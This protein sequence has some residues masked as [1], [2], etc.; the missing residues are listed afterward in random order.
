[1]RNNPLN[2]SDPTGRQGR[3]PDDSWRPGDPRRQEIA[4]QTEAAPVSLTEVAAVAVEVIGVLWDIATLPTGA[5]SGPEGIVA[6][7]AI[8]AGIRE[9]GETAAEGA[10]RA[11]PD[12]ITNS[13]GVTMSTSRDYNLVDTQTPTNRGGD[14][15]QIHNTHEHGGVSPHTH[16]PG[17][18]NTGAGGQSRARETQATT[19][20][21][22]TRAD[23]RLRSGELRE[24]R[25]RRD[26][27]GTP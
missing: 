5:G 13:E 1:M 9:S 21:D 6:S 24:R 15:M 27:G 19:G 11:G 8:A 16:Q 2:A 26:Q 7:R 20:R 17:P 3:P 23:T 18:T 22:M 14:W 12:F 25:N 10:A 4:R